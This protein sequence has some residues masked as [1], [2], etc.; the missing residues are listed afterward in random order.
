MTPKSKYRR[1]S[2]T[3]TRHFFITWHRSDIK[4]V[5]P[6]S[7]RKNSEMALNYYVTKKGLLTV[8]KFL[9]FEKYVYARKFPP[10]TDHS[11]L[12]WPMNLKYPL[13]QINRWVERLQEC[14]CHRQQQI[15]HHTAIT[16]SIRHCPDKY[17]Q[18]LSNETVS[19]TGVRLETG[20]L[21]RSL[22]TPTK[23]IAFG[24][25]VQKSY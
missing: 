2:L 11:I 19:A 21:S 15:N 24:I 14:D 20:E 9:I 22:N 16:W 13:G 18:S 25:T 10:R 6:L 1:K 4:I 12:K 17:K 8:V 3:N 5:K 7:Q 23:R